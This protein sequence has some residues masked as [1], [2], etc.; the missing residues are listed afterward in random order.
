MKFSF[1]IPHNKLR[2]AALLASTDETRYCLCGVNVEAHPGGVLLIATDGRRMGIFRHLTEVTSSDGDTAPAWA[3]PKFTID[4]ELITK[5]DP[6]VEGRA[7]NRAVETM[8]D[9]DGGTY[10]ETE[11]VRV[12]YETLTGEVSILSNGMT[13]KKDAIKVDS[14]CFFPDWRKAIPPLDV[15]EGRTIP[16]NEYLLRSFCEVCEIFEDQMVLTPVSRPPTINT[17]PADRGS[18]H[19]IIVQLRK[20]RDF[21][22]LLMPVRLISA[23]VKEEPFVFGKPDW[24]K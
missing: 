24:I 2:A 21:F 14:K 15:Y 3:M 16:V 18:P 22:G 9:Y 1:T 20:N 12:S 7:F 10:P 6:C 17:E 13:F 4:K 5:A 8:G 11:D 23:T 19:T